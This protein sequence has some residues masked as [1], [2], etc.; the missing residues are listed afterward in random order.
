LV[1]VLVQDE[2]RQL[3]EEKTVK[4]QD[5]VSKTKSD[6]KVDKTLYTEEFLREDSQTSTQNTTQ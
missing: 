2:L 4:N 1:E 6:L 5:Q 3:V